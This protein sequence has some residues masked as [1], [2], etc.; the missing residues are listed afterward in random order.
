MLHY[1]FLMAR[2][3][4]YHQLRNFTRYKLYTYSIIWTSRG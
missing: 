4:G 2:C 1:N 3:P